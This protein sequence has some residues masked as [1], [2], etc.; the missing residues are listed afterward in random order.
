MHS[1]GFTMLEVLIVIAIIGI[2]AGMGVVSGR[3][4][5]QRQ[6]QNAASR[7]I[8]QLFWQGATGA[9]AR[10]VEVTLERNDDVFTL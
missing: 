8:Q 9:A 3:K 10:G 4:V 6:N 2:V 5:A 7:S 1:R